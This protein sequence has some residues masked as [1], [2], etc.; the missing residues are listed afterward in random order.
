[1]SR[2]LYNIITAKPKEPLG[3]LIS[4]T[5][6]ICSFFYFFIIGLR[7]L[8]YNLGLF[9]S[10]RLKP[11]VISVGNI[12]WG[13]TGKTPL[14]E[15]ICL[16]F[17]NKGKR[18]TLLTRGYGED[19]D[20]ALSENMPGV[21]V[22][23]GPNRLKNALFKQEKEKKDTDLF[24]LDDGFQHWKISRDIDIVTINGVNPY[25]KAL[26]IPAG[27][28]R[29]PFANLSRADLV[30]ITKSNL[31]SRETLNHIK[32]RILKLK[33][34]M[35]IFEAAHCPVLF[36]T[37]KGEEKPLEY[38]KGRGICAVSGLGDN[39]SFM[40]TLEDLGCDL[41]LKFS[42]MDHHRYSAKDV[43]KIMMDCKKN[44]IDIIATTQKDWV[45]IEQLLSKD[46]LDGIEILVLKIKL[47]VDDEESFFGRLS[48]ILPG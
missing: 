1:M 6:V 33:P 4:A 14:V 17:N 48:S 20:K 35:A 24:I 23:V 12:T 32:E 25:G 29:E 21:S 3:I 38:V 11:P 44:S 7:R 16:Y 18:I 22:L 5:L 31:V 8:L 37:A 40:R 19:E 15:T 26:L 2:Y 28:M 41:K 47:K 13:G 39:G 45:K 34:D 30:V 46:S 36:C 27:I 9:K 43:D 10:V 42:Y